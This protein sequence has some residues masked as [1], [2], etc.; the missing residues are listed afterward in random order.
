[1]GMSTW[2]IRGGLNSRLQV[3][4][5]PLIW[6]AELLPFMTPNLRGLTPRPIKRSRF[7]RSIYLPSTS[8]PLDHLR[9]LRPIWIHLNRSI[10][11]PANSQ[12]SH[13]SVSQFDWT[14]GLT[15]SEIRSS[16]SLSALLVSRINRIRL[17]LEEFRILRMPIRLFNRY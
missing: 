4:N 5:K 13:R 3:E 11:V 9:L 12:G 8:G 6:I 15:F 14:V 2:I 1:M 16:S 7:K 17:F 10:L